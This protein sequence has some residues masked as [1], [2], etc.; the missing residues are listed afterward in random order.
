MQSKYIG[1]QPCCVAEIILINLWKFFSHPLMINPELLIIPDVHG[2]DFY[3]DALSEAVQAGIGIVCL[4]DYMDPY[5]EDDVHHMGV[6]YP[7]KELL[8]LKKMKPHMIHLLIGNHDASYFYSVEMCPGR[9]DSINAKDYHSFFSKNALMF[10]LFYEFQIIGKR[11]LF[12]HAG[13]TRGWLSDIGFGKQTLD[14]SLKTLNYGFKEYCIDNRKTAIWHQLSHVGEGRGGSYQEGSIIWS[15][16]FEHTD[17]SNWLKETGVIQVIGHTQLNY[18]PVRVAEKVFCLDCNE[19]FYIDS[20]GLIRS[21]KTDESI[22][23][24]DDFSPK[25]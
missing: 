21:F 6:A 14:E 1:A 13:I 5:D 22:M 11:F 25:L 19:C 15:D 17:P 10:D 20:Q 7:L 4:G 18:R 8:E 23:D 16:F 3:R 2:R 24:T 12:S 9:Y